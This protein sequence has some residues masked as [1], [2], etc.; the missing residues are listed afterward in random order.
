MHHLLYIAGIPPFDKIVLIIDYSPLLNQPIT[1]VLILFQTAAAHTGC[2]TTT[3]P[4]KIP[5]NVKIIAV[6]IFIPPCRHL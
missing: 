4:K 5:I 2:G 1:V 3:Q 6:A